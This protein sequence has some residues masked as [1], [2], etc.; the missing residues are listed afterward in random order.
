MNTSDFPYYKP[1]IGA[2]FVAWYTYH[3]QL[4]SVQTSDINIKIRDRNDVIFLNLAKVSEAHYIITGDK[5]LLILKT[6]G[7]TKIVTPEEFIS[8]EFPELLIY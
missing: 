4:F 7:K 5:D 3:S 1:R 8:H 6:F 2:V